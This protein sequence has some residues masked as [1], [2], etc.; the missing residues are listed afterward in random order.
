MLRYDDDSRAAAPADIRLIDM[1]WSGDAGADKYLFNPNPMLGRNEFRP[2]AVK[3]GVVMEQ[4][5]DVDT[6]HAS[7][8]TVY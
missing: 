4:Q 2:E 8:F 5:H 7:W 6:W 1:D 3:C